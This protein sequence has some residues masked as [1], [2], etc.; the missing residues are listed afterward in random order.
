MY[1]GHHRT[2]AKVSKDIL[3]GLTDSGNTLITKH[4]KLIVLLK[5]VVNEKR[6]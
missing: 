6:L 1:T 4:Y 2:L 5:N 3:I